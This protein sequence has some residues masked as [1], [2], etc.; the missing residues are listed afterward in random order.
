MRRIARGGICGGVAAAALVATTLA[1]GAEQAGAVTVGSNLANRPANNTV[2]CAINPALGIPWAGVG[3]INSCTW[4]GTGSLASLAESFVLPSGEG[5]LTAARVKVGPQTGPMQVVVY[6]SLRA[7]DVNPPPPSGGIVCCDVQFTSAPFTPAPNTTTTIPLPNVPVVGDRVPLPT[8]DP[9]DA[10]LR[11]DTVGLTVLNATTPFP[12]HRTFGQEGVQG[13]YPGL[14]PQEERLPGPG[15]GGYVPLMNVEWV[16]AASG[17]GGGGPGN[18]GNSGDDGTAGNSG[19]TSNARCGGKRAT[20]VG[21]NGRDVIRGTPKADVIHALG[22]NDVVRGLGGNDTICMG[23][24]K[25]RAFG[26]PGNDKILGQAGND[27]MDGQAGNDDLRGGPGRD[28]AFGRAGNDKMF[29]GPG[30]DRLL[31]GPGRDRLLGG[32]GRDIGIG[33]GAKDTC[34]TERSRAC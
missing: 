17:G 28:I 9:R 6:R 3:P 23:K 18:S 11:F 7:P 14:R 32:P 10:V 20:I 16:P 19:N 13:F 27:R 25:D 24:G 5:R 15:F 2:P 12:A 8:P 4:V 26:G 34:R 22:G 29:G 33:G 1:G 21:T 31:G 30:R